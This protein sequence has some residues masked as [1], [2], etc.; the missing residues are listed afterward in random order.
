MS[1]TM[2]AATA[3]MYVIAAAGMMEKPGMAFAFL[4]YAF[5]NLGFIYELMEK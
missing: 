3:L 5:A 4:C 2:L 1:A